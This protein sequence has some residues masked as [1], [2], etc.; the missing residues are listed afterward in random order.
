MLKN[1]LLAMLVVHSVVATWAVVANG[2]AAAGVAKPLAILVGVAAG[3][4]LLA[5][6]ARYD[7]D[8]ITRGK[9]A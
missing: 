7:G 9:Y 4:V 3:G 5:A 2:L 1:T 6:L 8:T